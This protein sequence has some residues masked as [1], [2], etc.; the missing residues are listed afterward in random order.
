MN[1]TPSVRMLRPSV[2]QQMSHL[3]GNGDVS[4]ELQSGCSRISLLGHQCTTCHCPLCILVQIGLSVVCPWH[5][6]TTFDPQECLHLF[7]EATTSG[8]GV[9][10]TGHLGRFCGRV[11][12]V[13]FHVTQGLG[14][15]NSVQGFSEWKHYAQ[16]DW[17]LPLLPNANP[18]LCQSSSFYSLC[19][20]WFARLLLR[21]LFCFAL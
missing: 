18:E 8:Q 13:L 9:T 20:A 10:V 6:G 12:L 3:V 16:L 17:V 5:P 19:F 1:T 4:V 7:G 11:S 2:A 15:L 21:T 14:D